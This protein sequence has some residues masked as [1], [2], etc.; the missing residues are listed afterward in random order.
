MLRMAWAEWWI[1]LGFLMAR[2]V[3][4]GCVWGG[5]VVSRE[6]ASHTIKSTGFLKYLGA[7]PAGPNNRYGMLSPRLLL[8]L[9]Q[10]S[11]GLMRSGG[12]CGG[13]INFWDNEN[14]TVPSQ[15][16]GKMHC[17]G[18]TDTARDGTNTST[19]RG[20]RL[21]LKKG[22]GSFINTWSQS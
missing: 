9:T 22:T 5:V 11:P 12:S 10:L 14:L 20:Q 13:R 15:L 17:W 19:L 1:M 16:I 7:L 18:H 8:Q 4:M 2:W 6:A 3:G 21:W